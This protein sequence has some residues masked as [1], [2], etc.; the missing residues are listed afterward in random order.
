MAGGVALGPSL[1]SVAGGDEA[2]DVGMAV[3]V[4]SVLAD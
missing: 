1:G 2:V 3:G 4:A